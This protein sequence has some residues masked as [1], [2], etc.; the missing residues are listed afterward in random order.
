MA[1]MGA[2]KVFVRFKS[3]VIGHAPLGA[4]AKGTSRDFSGRATEIVI[5][6]Y[7]PRRG[8]YKTFTA[9]P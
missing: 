1:L 7:M 6:F 5:E 8:L 4:V 9:K 3:N 2:G